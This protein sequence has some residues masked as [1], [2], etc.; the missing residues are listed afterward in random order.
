MIPV[1]K[2]AHNILFVCIKNNLSL[3]RHTIFLPK[4]NQ[5]L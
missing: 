5:E 3:H 1:K 4:K 2:I